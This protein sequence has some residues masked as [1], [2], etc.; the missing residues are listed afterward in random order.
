MPKD[1]ENIVISTGPI[2]GSQKVYVEHGDL[3]IPFREVALEESANEPPVR[4]YDTSG[5][6]TDANFAPAVDEGLPRLREE[7]IRARGDVVEYDGRTLRPEDNHREAGDPNAFPDFPN[8]RK[9]LRAEAGGNVSQMHYARKG[10]ITPEMEFVAHRENLGRSEFYGDGE[11]FGANIPEFVTPEFVRKE[12]AEGR[13]IIPANIN[14]PEAEPMAIGRNFLVK[15]NAN[16]GNSAISSSVAE[17]VEK[18]VWATRWGAD[19][20]M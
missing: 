8:L 7:W 19:T 15:I 16:I 13:A 1:S 6:Y 14:H 17:E 10:I 20:V 12:I 18:M 3:R 11:T 9:P 5:P 4:L 2:P